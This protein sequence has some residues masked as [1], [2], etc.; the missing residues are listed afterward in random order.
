MVVAVRFL[1]KNCSLLSTKQVIRNIHHCTREKV[2]GF[3]G[4]LFYA[5]GNK[6]KKVSIIMIPKR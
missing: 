3:P 6:F 1:S 2:S 4:R 5:V